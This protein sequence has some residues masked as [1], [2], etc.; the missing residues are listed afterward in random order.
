MLKLRFATPEMLVDI[1]DLP[2]LDYHTIGPDGTI[3]IGAL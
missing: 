2:D 3:R 1:N